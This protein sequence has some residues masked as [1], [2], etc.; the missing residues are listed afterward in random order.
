MVCLIC[1]GIFI[2]DTASA[3][4]PHL[5]IGTAH[6]AQPAFMP[7]LQA[8]RFSFKVRCARKEGSHKV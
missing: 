5:R 3:V 2:G 6:P 1:A 8:H 7:L 4:I